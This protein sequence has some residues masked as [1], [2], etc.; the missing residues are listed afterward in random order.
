MHMNFYDFILTINSSILVMLVV[1]YIRFRINLYEN[2][3]RQFVSSERC[4]IV[5]AATA[6]H[7]KKIEE[8]LEKLND[9]IDRLYGKLYK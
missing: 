1:D 9:K 3:T 4:D 6:K 5:S 7:L 8:N 2:I